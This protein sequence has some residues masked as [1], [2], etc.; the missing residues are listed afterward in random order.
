MKEGFVQHHTVVWGLPPALGD[1]WRWMIGLTELGSV[2]LMHLMWYDSVPTLVLSVIGPMLWVGITMGGTLTHI[3]CD[4]PA[5]AKPFCGTVCV[6]NV[7]QL[8]LRVLYAG[9]SITADATHTRLY[10]G[11]AGGPA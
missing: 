3:L 9:E 4:D 8:V 11:L 5:P 2:V 7:V 6:L 10:Q 1:L